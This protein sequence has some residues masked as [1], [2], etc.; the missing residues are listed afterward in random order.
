MKIKGSKSLKYLPKTFLSQTIFPPT[1]I[2]FMM[3]K[4]ERKPLITRKTS[5]Y[6]NDERKN[7]VNGELKN[8][9]NLLRLVYGTR[10]MGISLR[11]INS[12]I[13]EI[14]FNPCK[15]LISSAFESSHKAL[16]FR[17]N[18]KHERILFAKESADFA[19]SFTSSLSSEVFDFVFKI[20]AIKGVSKYS[21]SVDK[22]VADI[23]KNM[24][25]L[26]KTF[27]S[28]KSKENLKTYY[29]PNILQS[30]LMR[31]TFCTLFRI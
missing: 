11:E 26:K 16:R 24:K 9:V 18:E 5:S 25:R 21:L 31:S 7:T 23:V 1:E 6:K 2:S 29:V 30:L 22:T 19:S 8:S 12:K 28:N 13:I 3:L 27:F 4:V 17:F 15:H 14:D 10:P 20:V